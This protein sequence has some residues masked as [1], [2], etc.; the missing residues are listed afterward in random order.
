M[1]PNE[2]LS[3]SAQIAVALAGFAGVVVAFRSG[4]IHEWSRVDKFRLRILL[5]NSGVPFG[6]SI[7]GMWL[8]STSLD[9]QR[10]WQIG[11]VLAFVAV[12]M[13]GQQMSR[14]MR[15]FSR[16]EFETDGASR[17]VFFSSSIVG[18]AVTL[19]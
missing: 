4:S 12:T 14:S 9:L 5:V 15:G 19:L 10:I 11:S 1:Q 18:V 8:L 6:L 13:T 16:Q 3:A 17:A 2:A 7:L